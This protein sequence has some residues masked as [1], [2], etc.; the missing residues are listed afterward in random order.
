MAKKKKK[1]KKIDK[2]TSQWYESKDE[3]KEWDS[4]IWDSNEDGE[5][6]HCK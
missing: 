4:S 2:D 1:R 3:C 6:D 5:I